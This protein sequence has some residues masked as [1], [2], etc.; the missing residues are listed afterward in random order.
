MRESLRLAPTAPARIV[1][2]KEDTVIGG[3]YAVK[4]GAALNMFATISQHDPAVWGE[5]VRASYTP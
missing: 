3:K 1:V 2:P 4:K 5:D